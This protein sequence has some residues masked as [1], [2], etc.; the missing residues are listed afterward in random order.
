MFIVYLTSCFKARTN[1]LLKLTG[2]TFPTRDNKIHFACVDSFLCNILSV[3]SNNIY[4]H[5]YGNPFHVTYIENRS[6]V[7]NNALPF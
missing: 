6:S 4:Q 2:S 5:L 1:S 3:F 7:Y